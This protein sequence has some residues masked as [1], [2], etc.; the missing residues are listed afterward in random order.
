MSKKRLTVG[1]L[2]PQAKESLPRKVNPSSAHPAPGQQ[3]TTRQTASR[4]LIKLKQHDRTFTL[5]PVSGTTL[6]DAA[7][8]QHQPIDYKCRKGDCGKCK[9]QVL[10]GSA[11]IS[12]PAPE[13][14]STL[15]K[16][17]AKGYRLACQTKIY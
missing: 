9:V 17:L 4:P 6:L 11:C 2:R 15:K 14:I 5:I 7:L 13:E 8:S 10:E 16:E 12:S 1:S 3:H